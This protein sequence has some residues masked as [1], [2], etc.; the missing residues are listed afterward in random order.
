MRVTIRKKK[1]RTV[2]FDKITTSTCPYFVPF[3]RWSLGK[4][5]T[6]KTL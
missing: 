2:A 4:I 5:K 3:I 6:V 1:G